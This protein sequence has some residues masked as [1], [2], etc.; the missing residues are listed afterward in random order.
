MS[1]R[2][3]LALDP[4]GAFDEGRGTTGWCLID[5]QQ[6][7]KI[8]DLGYIDA[9]KHLCAPEYWDANVQLIEKYWNLY[10]GEI[11]LVMEDYVLYAEKS[12]AQIN[13]RMETSRLIGVI[14]HHCWKLTMPYSMQFANLVVNR[15]NDTVLQ[16]KRIIK[17]V[18]RNTFVLF[19]NPRVYLNPHMKDA[20]RHGIHYATFRNGGRTNDNLPERRRRTQ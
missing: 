7:F 5:T 3:I 1:Y 15:W 2:Y 12:S 17:E 4:S 9:G 20:I 16:Y 19:D 14:Q 8:L 10:R 18:R 11:I 13:S 6:G